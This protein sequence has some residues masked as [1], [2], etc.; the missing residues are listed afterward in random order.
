MKKGSL[1]DQLSAMLAYRNR[2]DIDAPVETARTNWTIVPANDNANPEEI[3][4][5][6]VERR[7]AIRPTIS[8]ILRESAEVDCRPVPVAD[9]SKAKGEHDLE[10]YPV[11]RDVE[12]GFATDDNGKRHRVVVRIG[13]LRFSDGTQ[14]E[15]GF[16]KG[17][18]GKLVIKDLE[19][20]VGA[21]LR[22][23]EQQERMLGG[24]GVSKAYI[25]QSN[26]YFA[27]MLG[28]IEP[29]YVKGTGRR[30]GRSYSAAESRTMLAEAYANT[31]V[32]PPVKR[33]RK[34]LPC[35]SQR[36]AESFLGMQ[37]GKKGESG[38][39]A[40]EDVSS[41]IVNREVWEATLTYLTEAETTVLDKALEAGSLAELG[42]GGHRRTRERQGRRKLQ[43]ANDNLLAAL[44]KSA[45]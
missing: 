36:V 13:R 14:T 32:L 25:E 15:K 44:K 45:A 12:Y 38:S 5:T 17:L 42:D 29:R 30:Y 23:E 9:V 6:H 37:K 3:A 1:A 34:G 24:N 10:L 28:A 40:W 19:M 18:D 31:P 33:Y 27:Q 8:K 22:T 41:H 43:A 26:L 4:N 20:P 39:I 16:A 35:G 7:L 21:M 2:A 11:A